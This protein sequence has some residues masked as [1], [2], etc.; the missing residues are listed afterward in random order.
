MTVRYINRKEDTYYLHRGKTKTGNPKYFFSRKKDNGLVSTLPKDYE[1]YENPNARVFLRRIPPK[2]ITDKELSIVEK[3]VKKYS[4]LKDFKLD[5]KK[6]KI[7]VFLPDQD[8]DLLKDLFL[9]IREP[10]EQKNISELEQ[11][12]KMNTTYSPMMQFVLIDKKTREFEVERYCFLCSID[13]WIII[14]CSTNL[15]KLVKEYSKHL[16]KDSLFELF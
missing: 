15:P 9:S 4:G 3:G 6:N 16:G 12:L 11:R 2:V 13:D 7:I 14:G 8:M 10:S 5:V 1:I